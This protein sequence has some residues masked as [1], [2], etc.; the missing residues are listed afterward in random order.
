MNRT[1]LLSLLAAGGALLLSI[2]RNRTLSAE[3]RR[4]E[5]TRDALS[6]DLERYRTRTGEQA[7]S[8]RALELTASELRRLRADDARRIR[9]LGIRLRRAESLSTAALS[10]ATPISAPLRDTVLLRDTILLRDTLR[11]FRWRD[12]WVAVD[13]TITPDSVHCVVRSRDTLRQVVHRVPRRFLFIRW[14]TKAIRQ[15]IVASNPRT[16][17]VYAEYVELP[18]RRERK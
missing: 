18:R 15:E 10:T 5:R 11:L 16:R 7:A 13:G 3:N 17:I 8:I 9:S 14:G 4:L 1:L 2:H 6:T 12:R